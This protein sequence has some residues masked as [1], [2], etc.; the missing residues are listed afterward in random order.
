[1]TTEPAVV[2]GHFNTIIVATIVSTSLSAVAKC[3]VVSL[4]RIKCCYPL[5]VIGHHTAGVRIL[6]RA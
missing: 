5:V 6:E 4:C 1:M 3:V 2:W